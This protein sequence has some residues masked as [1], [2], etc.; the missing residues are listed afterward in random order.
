M[1]TAETIITYLPGS[2]YGGLGVT[3]VVICTIVIMVLHENGLIS[4]GPLVD[5]SF[6]FA[7]L[8]LLSV[9][10]LLSWV[11]MNKYDIPYEV[12]SPM[13]AI[14]MMGTVFLTSVIAVYCKVT[15]PTFFLVN[16]DRS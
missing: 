13:A 6:L 7:A 3:C 14:F 4:K 11:L 8:F 1:E 12:I 10:P 2:F 5:G 16:E 9:T 15:V